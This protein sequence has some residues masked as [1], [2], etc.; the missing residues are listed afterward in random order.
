M[1]LTSRV[2]LNARPV[3]QRSRNLPPKEGRHGILE[4]AA[5]DETTRAAPREARSR[6][7]PPCGPPGRVRRGWA[8]LPHL[9]RVA[10][11][12]QWSLLAL[13]TD[14]KRR[15]W[16]KSMKI[17]AHGSTPGRQPTAAD[18]CGGSRLTSPGSR[19]RS[20]IFDP[21]CASSD[22]QV[23]DLATRSRAGFGRESRVPSEPA[24]LILRASGATSS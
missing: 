20:A 4:D 5:A 13:L 18:R 23:A 17:G 12:L 16:W 22:A 6:S 3:A 19:M 15:S 11:G 14:A 8:P 7:Q 1:L 10:A 9:K 24:R 2:D 21:S